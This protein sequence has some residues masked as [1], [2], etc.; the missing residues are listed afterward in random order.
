MNKTKTN[1]KSKPKQTAEKQAVS[2]DE[3]NNVDEFWYNLETWHEAVAV[4]KEYCLIDEGVCDLADV[5]ATYLV[6]THLEKE[7]TELRK[8]LPDYNEELIHRMA[9]V[10]LTYEANQYYDS[11]FYN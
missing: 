6:K 7:C 10:N 8:K 1:T 5:L 9:I 11:A 4:L 3:A 2:N